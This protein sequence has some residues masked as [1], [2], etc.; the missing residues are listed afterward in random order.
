MRL[1]VEGFHHLIRDFNARRIRRRD[2]MSLNGQTSLGFGVVD[3]VEYQVKGSERT[4]RPGFADFAEQPMFDGIPFGGP[5]RIMAN[6]DGQL[7]EI[8]HFFLERQFPGTA[9]RSI[10]PPTLGQDFQ[11]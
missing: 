3:I 9:A 1:D 10:A 2:K 5:D 4:A 8:G 6:G 11:C 7:K